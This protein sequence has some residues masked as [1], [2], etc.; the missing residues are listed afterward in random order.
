MYTYKLDVS[1]SECE[2]SFI[3]GCT[4]PQMVTFKCCNADACTDLLFCRKMR[5]MTRRSQNAQ[6]CLY[7]LGSAI[8]VCVFW[9]KAEK[10]VK[11]EEKSFCT[12]IGLLATDTVH[13]YWPTTIVQ[14]APV[15]VLEPL[16][17]SFTS[18]CRGHSRMKATTFELQLPI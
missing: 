3:V 12:K 17:N 9:E 2:S 10:G 5:K 11:E 14:L 8:V 4:A 16:D 15:P 1:W 13:F 7:N 6:S 18:Q